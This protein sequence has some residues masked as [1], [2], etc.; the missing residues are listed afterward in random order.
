MDEA[1][2]H[3]RVRDYFY[4]NHSI[5][6][7]SG[8]SIHLVKFSQSQ[9]YD[10]CLEGLPW[11]MADQQF[12]ERDR[13]VLERQTGIPALLVDARPFT[14]PVPAERLDA[15]IQEYAHPFRHTVPEPVSL[16]PVTCQALFASGPV[17][18]AED[19]AGSRLA[20]IWYQ[21]A[22]AMP[23]DAIVLEKLRALDWDAQAVNF[24]H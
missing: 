16:G 9:T 18:G 13:Q 23:I 22:F 2:D 11:G 5:Q 12:A 19:A 21:Q 20:L 17:P 15:F 8:R 3:S 6:L 24:S 14:L 7:S 10:A 4:H 1:N